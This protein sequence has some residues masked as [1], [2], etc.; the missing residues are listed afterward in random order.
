[1]THTFP[2]VLCISVRAESRPSPL[3]SHSA[4]PRAH[5]GI[6]ALVDGNH[7]SHVFVLFGDIALTSRR[8]NVD[9]DNQGTR[10]RE[11]QNVIYS[12]RG[13]TLPDIV[14][15]QPIPRPP[16]ATSAGI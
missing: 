7:S 16:P 14:S 15:G 10:P 12:Y 9:I 4:T 5:L 1:M 11:G 6:M 3:V 2:P 13:N 8:Y